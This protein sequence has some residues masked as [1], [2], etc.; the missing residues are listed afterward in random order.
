MRAMLENLAW[1]GTEGS[2]TL[3]RWRPEQEMQVAA[4]DVTRRNPW[5]RR[6]RLHLSRRD[7]DGD[8]ATAS[9]RYF[10]AGARSLQRRLARRRR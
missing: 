2:A 3:A 6:R 4:R 8:D 9:P 10:L 1:R 5:A 7:G